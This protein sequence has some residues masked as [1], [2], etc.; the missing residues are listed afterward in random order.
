MELFKKNNIIKLNKNKRFFRENK[1]KI[2]I[3]LRKNL[4]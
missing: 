3:E 2:D 1:K 4:Y